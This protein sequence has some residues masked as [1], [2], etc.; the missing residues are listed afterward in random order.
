VGRG[1][2]TLTAE[3]RE[4][5]LANADRLAL[6]ESMWQ[7]AVARPRSERY[8]QMLAEVLPPQFA[9]GATDAPSATGLWRTLRAAEAAGALKGR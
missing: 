7:D 4:P 5:Q 9:D 2:R 1:Q 3:Y 8:R 6:L